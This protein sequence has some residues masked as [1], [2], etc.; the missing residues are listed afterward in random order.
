MSSDSKDD[1]ERRSRGIAKRFLQTAVVVDDEAYINPDRGGR[2]KSEVIVPDRHTRTSRLDPQEQSGRRDSHTL[3][4]ASLIDSFSALGVICGVVNPMSAAM[5]TMKQAD[6]VILDWRLQEDD[7]DRALS[8]L[9][10]LLTVE[11]DRH[12]LRL[13][14]I[15]TGEASL[16]DIY[17]KIF[18]KLED[19]RLEPKPQ[20]TGFEMEIPYRHGRVVLYAKYGVNLA[21]PLTERCVEEKDLPERLAE[22]FASMT[23]GLLPGIALTSLAAVREGAHRVLDRFS[24]KLDPAFLTHRTCLPDP[25]DAE[26]QIVNHVAQELRGLMDNAVAEESPGGAGAVEGWIR[27]KGITEFNFGRKKLDLQEI[28]ILATKGLEKSVLSKKEQKRGHEVLSAG[29]SGDNAGGLDEQLAWIMSYRTVYSAPPPILWL[30]TVVTDMSDGNERHLICMKPRCDCV[31]LEQ[32]TSFF[33]L[34]LGEPK[35][36][37]EQIIVRLDNDKFKRMGIEPDSAGWVIRDFDPASEPGAVTAA[38]SDTGS[39]F[40]F[41]DACG[42]RYKWRGELKVEYAQRIV[43]NFSATLARV[44]VDESE[45]LRRIKKRDETRAETCAAYHVSAQTGWAE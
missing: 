4:A 35:E 27:R 5:E 18:T 9:N 29:F 43:Q 41:K 21:P 7:P 26:R 38:K 32:K 1:F 19:S 16:Q 3:D 37:P 25:E 39:H 36:E 11:A 12:S 33:F 20:K 45:W 31:R 6:I 42:K 40:E 44:A 23:E 24:M 30:G 28:I 34:P 15:Y 10:G 13:V 22:D 2:P 17:E 8:L 14:A